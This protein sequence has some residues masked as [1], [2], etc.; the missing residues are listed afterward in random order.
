[1]ESEVSITCHGLLHILVHAPKQNVWGI[2]WSRTFDVL[3]F[4]TSFGIIV[5]AESCSTRITPGKL[6]NRLEVS[7]TQ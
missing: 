1:M 2:G 4:R 5:L 7:G 6:L 3:K